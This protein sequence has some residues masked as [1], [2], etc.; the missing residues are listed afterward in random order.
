MFLRFWPPKKFDAVALG[1][2]KPTMAI[3]KARAVEPAPYA[4]L[5]CGA[6]LFVEL[7]RDGFVHLHVGVDV[8]NV[9]VLFERVNE[10]VDRLGH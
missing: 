6:S 2:Y 1:P 3:N 4:F 10:L 8:L 7:V 9:I 5:A